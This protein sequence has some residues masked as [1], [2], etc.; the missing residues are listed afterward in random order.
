MH[1]LVCLKFRD[2]QLQTKKMCGLW[3]LY[4]ACVGDQSQIFGFCI[5]ICMKSSWLI[6]NRSSGKKSN[7][8][9]DDDDN[10]FIENCIAWFI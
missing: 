2:N 8:M 1:L 5:H 6:V 4:Y 3:V 10:R 9:V 7:G